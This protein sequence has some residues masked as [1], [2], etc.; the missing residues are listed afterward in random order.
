[1]EKEKYVCDGHQRH[2]FTRPGWVGEYLPTCVR[3]G[4]P[5]PRLAKHEIE[6]PNKSLNTDPKGRDDNSEAER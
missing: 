4:A 2:W 1:M 6:T 5:N 3:C